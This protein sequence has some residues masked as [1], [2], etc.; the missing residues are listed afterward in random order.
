MKPNRRRLIVSG[1]AGLAGS[2]PLPVPA[3]ARQDRPFR[4]YMILYRGETPVERGFRDY[5]ASRNVAMELI[6]RDIA[7]DTGKIPALIAEARALHADLIY[8]WGTPV[9]L[10]VAG[11][12]ASI[13]PVRNVTD[14]PIV[15]TMVA[16][17]E[18]SGL[19]AS[20]ASSGRNITGDSHVVPVDQQLSAIRAYRDFARLAVIYNPVEPNSVLNVKQLREASRRERFQLI[21]QPIPL[22]AQNKPLESSLPQLIADAASKKP[23]FLYLGPDSFIGANCKLVTESALEQGLPAFSA[24]EAAL[25]EGKALFGLVSRY[26]NVGRLAAYK[27]EQILVKKMRP[28]D[29]PIET[30]ARFSYI[31]NMSVAARLGFYPPLKVVNYAEVIR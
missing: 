17:P 6:V 25:R 12:H 2:L 26:D 5:L 31:V 18:G 24:T 15:F 10:A 3:Q 21:E 9:T 27:A 23:Q 8:T 19:I 14:I 13:D 11:R 16:S 1:L 20:R 30:L 22:D 29:I 4:I 7:Q 28:R